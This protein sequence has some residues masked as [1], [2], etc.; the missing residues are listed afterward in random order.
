MI[1]NFMNRHN[2]D[3][4]YCIKKRFPVDDENA[5]INSLILLLSKISVH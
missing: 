4:C 2:Y 5:N 1:G 3:D